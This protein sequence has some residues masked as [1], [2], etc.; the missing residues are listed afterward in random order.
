VLTAAALTYVAAALI[1]ALQLL[2]YMGLAQR[3]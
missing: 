3:D 1:A 2:Y